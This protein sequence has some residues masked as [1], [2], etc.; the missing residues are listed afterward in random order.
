[1]WKKPPLFGNYSPEKLSPPRK[2]YKIHLI[3]LSKL[4]HTKTISNFMALF[5]IS[6]SNSKY[7]FFENPRKKIQKKGL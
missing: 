4:P 2:N 7:D 3:F 1:M 6:I 5:E